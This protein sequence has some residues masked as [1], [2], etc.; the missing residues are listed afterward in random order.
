MRLL[1]G[2]L[3][4]L[5]PLSIDM[6]LPAL[7]GM[8]VSFGAPP[9]RAA[10][11][12]SMFLLGFAAS[13]LAY[14]P[15]SDRFGRKPVLMFGCVVFAAASG[16]CMHAGS[17]KELVIWRGIAGAGMVLVRAIVRDLFD[18]PV[19]GRTQFSDINMVMQVA[20]VVAPLL[21]GGDEDGHYV[22][23]IAL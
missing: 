8:A 12:L 21:G 14:R 9:E 18:D 4:A 22:Y 17:L 11:T 15:A 13:Q 10:A 6:N 23:A 3:A 2:A 19:A 5:P 1:L 16:A 20:P 7:P